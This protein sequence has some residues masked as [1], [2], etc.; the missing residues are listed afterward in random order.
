MHA[1]ATFSSYNCYISLLL[2]SIYAAG[3][4]MKAEK[5][6]AKGCFIFIQYF[7]WNHQFCQ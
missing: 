3:L 4:T 1:K 7:Q 6:I 5:W 2:K